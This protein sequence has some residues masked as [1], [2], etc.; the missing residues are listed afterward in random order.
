MLNQLTNL[1]L[2][3]ILALTFVI[4]TTVSII[5]MMQVFKKKIGRI[6]DQ[7]LMELIKSDRITKWTEEANKALEYIVDEV[8]SLSSSNEMILETIYE[9]RENRQQ[10]PRLHR[11][12]PTPD[13]ARAI[14]QTIKDQISNEMA[15]S[16]KLKAPPGNYVHTIV[17]TVAETY[18]QINIEYLSKRCIS[19]IEMALHSR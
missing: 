19:M 1:E 14:D 4:P 7:L 16:Y 18:P 12:F 9:E 2:W 5:F 3:L 13:L 8:D 17:R 6:E 10:R 15:L 11:Q